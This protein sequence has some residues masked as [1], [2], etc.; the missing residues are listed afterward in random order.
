MRKLLAVASSIALC[1]TLATAQTKMSGSY[2]INPNGSGTRNFKTFTEAAKNL[3]F[4]EVSG[5]VTIRV[6]SGTYKESFF[7]LPVGGASTTNRITFEPLIP[8][9]QSV[10]LQGTQGDIIG[11][12]QGLSFF[13]NGYYTFK[14]FVFESCT[15]YAVS[16][17]A[18]TESVEIIGC[19]FSDK[20]FQTSSYP[21]AQIYANG[22]ST[23]KAWSL[24]GNSFK[25]KSGS[26]YSG[27]YG[28]QIETWEIHDNTFDLNGV[29]YG[30]YLI[31]DNRALNRI[32][33]N[34]FYGNVNTAAVYVAAS[35]LNNDIAHNTFYI[36]TTSSNGAAVGT[37]GTSSNYNRIYGNIM[38][39]TGAQGSCI[40]VAISSSSLQHWASDG[41]LFFTPGGANV[42][43]INTTPYKTLANWQANGNTNQTDRDQNSIQADPKFINATA[44][45]PDLHVAFDSKAKDSAV[46]TPSFV[47]DDFDGRYRDAKP[48]IGAFELAGFAIFG[49]GCKGTGGKIPTL[50]STGTVD[51]G[52]VFQVTVANGKPTTPALMVLGFSTKQWLSFPLPFDVG[53]GCSLLVSLDTILPAALDANGAAMLPIAVPND[54]NLRGQSL[55]FQWLV[56]DSVSAS[57]LGLTVSNGGAANL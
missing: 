50:G 23:N 52:K 13:K 21:Y 41:N 6:M 3:F 42:G 54:P 22:A 45:P 34:L 39:V 31:N 25:F 35:N 40:R 47:V 10:K 4:N 20:A 36:N 14:N 9:P 56:V 57:P 17:Q 37:F 15:G 38:A 8:T 53:G 18:Y 28:S 5:P 44:T 43:M 2:T 48:D 12:F 16:A 32:Y 33:N 29:N 27:I 30:I 11:M 51:I 1:A 49:T 26:S 7:L 46:K 19:E 24:V 55:N